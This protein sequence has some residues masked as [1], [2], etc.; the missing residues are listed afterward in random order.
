MTVSC[1]PIGCPDIKGIKT[2]AELAAVAE[3]GPIGCPDIK[4]IKTPTTKRLEPI[5]VR[6]VA[7]IS[8][9]LRRCAAVTVLLLEGPIGCPDIKGIKTKGNANL[10]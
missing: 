5:A 3:L 1:R 4:G 7:L 2:I 10:A 6:S 8:K 9:G